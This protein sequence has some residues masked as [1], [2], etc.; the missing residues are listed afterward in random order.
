MKLKRI[1]ATKSD[2]KEASKKLKR[3]VDTAVKKDVICPKVKKAS[4]SP[5]KKHVKSPCLTT[6]H[7]S[8]RKLSKERNRSESPKVKAKEVADKARHHVKKSREPEVVCKD[9]VK[10]K[11]VEKMKNDFDKSKSY[12]TEEKSVRCDER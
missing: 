6:A 1:G 5:T 2:N 4:S 10:S 9:A 12:S 11:T 7:C 3:K 8:V